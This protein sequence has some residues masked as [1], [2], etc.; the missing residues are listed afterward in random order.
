[1]HLIKYVIIYIKVIL[2]RY[3][4]KRSELFITVFELPIKNLNLLSFW[5]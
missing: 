4:Y 5:F 2:S 1:M 3:L